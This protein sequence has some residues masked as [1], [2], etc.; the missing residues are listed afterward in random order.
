MRWFLLVSAERHRQ[1][2]SGA[3]DDVPHFNCLNSAL[4]ETAAIYGEPSKSVKVGS[5]TNGVCV[6]DHLDSFDRENKAKEQQ[7]RL[8]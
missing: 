3:W 1:I 6:E 7:G 4:P 2:K 8:G 5:V